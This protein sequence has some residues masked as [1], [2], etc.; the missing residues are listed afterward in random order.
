MDRIK[1]LFKDLI[2]LSFNGKDKLNK[3]F[4]ILIASRKIR[5]VALLMRFNIGEKEV[6]I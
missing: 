6:R 5:I 2:V 3:L 1:I 4:L